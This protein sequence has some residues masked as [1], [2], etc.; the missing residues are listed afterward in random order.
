MKCNYLTPWDALAHCSRQ[1]GAAARQPLNILCMTLIF[2][3]EEPGGE[4][5]RGYN[6]VSYFLPSSL[7]S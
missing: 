5:M 7:F 6:F 4:E 1:N 2:G 3:V